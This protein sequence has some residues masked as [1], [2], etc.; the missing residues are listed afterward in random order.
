[1]YE[2]TPGYWITLPGCTKAK[3]PKQLELMK[4][5]NE[6]AFIEIKSMQEG[7][8]YRREDIDAARK[9]L[10][11][12][13]K[14]TRVLTEMV[15]RSLQGTESKPNFELLLHPDHFK[16]ATMATLERI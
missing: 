2:W 13:E 5:V 14:R 9:F 3:T 16:K 4:L 7:G 11:F 12:P 6:Q 1:M 8:I 15:Y 10:L